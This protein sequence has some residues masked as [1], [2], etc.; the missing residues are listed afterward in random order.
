MYLF[1]CDPVYHSKDNAYKT[2]ICIHIFS[3]AHF[4][5]KLILISRIMSMECV[6]SNKQF[7]NNF[8]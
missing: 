5:S 6:I 8:W 4:W 7:A 3:I 2:K 1:V